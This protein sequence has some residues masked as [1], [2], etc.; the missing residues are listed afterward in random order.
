[1]SKG[2]GGMQM[3]TRGRVRT[4]YIVF[5]VV[6]VL[7]ILSGLL[8]L[9]PG[10]T[11]GAAAK[12]PIPPQPKVEAPEPIEHVSYRR[13]SE[14][15]PG[16]IRV[17]IRNVGKKE[18]SFKQVLLD[19]LPISVWGV[20]LSCEKMEPDTPPETAHEGGG[21]NF[22][23]VASKLSDKRI[24][25]ARLAPPHIPQG[26]IGELSIKLAN[27]LP[28]PMRVLLVPAEGERIPA[29]VR[30]VQ[31]PLSISAVTFS[32][33]LD[34]LYVYLDSCPQMIGGPRP[35]PCGKAQPQAA[36]SSGTGAGA[37]APAGPLRVTGVEIDGTPVKNGLWLS[38]SV[39]QKGEKHLAVVAL[40]Q[41]L[42]QGSY[43]TVRVACENGISAEER[44]RMFSGFPLNVESGDKLPSGYGLD[45][46]PYTIFPEYAKSAEPAKAA[47]AKPPEPSP[48]A[49]Y[50]FDCAMHKFAGDQTRC[51][52]ETFR[53]YD[54]CARFDPYHPSLI[55]MCRIRPETGYAL[56]G[57][58]TDIL[59]F[60]PNIT[61]GMSRGREGESPEEVVERITRY[62]YFGAR[63][64][65]AQALADTAKFGNDK[66]LA[67][68]EESRRRVYTML[69]CG[70]KGLLYRHR[71]WEDTSSPRL[72]DEIK[73]L[74]AEIHQIRPYLN[75]ADVAEWVE[76][77][78]TGSMGAYSLLASDQA[79]VV[80]LVSHESPAGEGT[81]DTDT[82]QKA[83]KILL[84]LPD[85][86]VPVSAF[87][88]TPEKLQPADMEWS[89]SGK[90][91]LHTRTP[92]AAEAYV[93]KVERG[94][95]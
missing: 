9:Y 71:G 54:I 84:T 68:P 82:A 24:V 34:R 52:K 58:T 36:S 78:G 17:Y 39:I 63:P 61:S 35:C 18:T 59:R 8:W 50:V 19:G 28:R 75:I 83:V 81:P 65:P 22:E 62:A 48:R 87:R 11:K 23:S 77:E 12:A 3:L 38:S 16:T 4:V 44:V 26:G 42:V 95:K 66:E 73:R 10:S 55:H 1:M 51:A 57:E 5:W 86:L 80:I 67:S 14:F 30:P 94:H 60:N 53:R 79:V 15:D 92:D 7:A 40:K 93:V 74:N 70:V 32:G 31:P 76:V 37:Q 21:E 33:T 56:F 85:W 27:P 89:S 25:W 72:D 29:L 88:V 90:V 13:T 91:V 6:L 69:G 2:G 41:P 64:R 46:Q 20:D 47:P 49:N 43:V 45:E